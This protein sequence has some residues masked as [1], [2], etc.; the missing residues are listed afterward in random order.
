MKKYYKSICVIMAVM[1]ICFTG[2][3]GKKQADTPTITPST[4]T[5]QTKEIKEVTELSEQFKTGI[6]NF[7]FQIFE[8]LEDSENIFISPYSMAIAISMLDNGAEGSSKEEIEQMLGIEDLE[9]WN[10][11]VAYYMSLHEED[12][13]KLLTANSLWLSE[14]IAIS[15]NAEN[16]FFNPVK[17]YY[18]SE[19]NQMDLTSEDT[20]NQINSWVSDN[21]KGMI[22]SILDEPLDVNIKMALLN[23]VYFKGEWKE[24]FEE[25]NTE[26]G[27]FYGKD[28]TSQADMMYQANA[29]YKY[30][31][32]DN[33]KAIELPY[34][35]GKIVMDILIPISAEEGNE[36]SKN[37]NELFSSLSMEEK[38]ELFAALSVTDEQTI[39]ILELPKFELEYGVK[40]ISTALQAIGMKAPF[41]DFG[42]SKISP[43]VKV[44]KVLHKAKIQIDEKG[45]EASAATT[46]TMVNDIAA[47]VD[48][49]IKEFI[50]DQPFIFVIRDVENDMILFMG[51]IQNL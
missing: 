37:M 26:K 2:C 47:F 50:V 28:E 3:A 16:D 4:T 42:F 35:N 25:E 19:K 49:E 36:K 18:H 29:K 7:S 1:M 44:E 51:S 41:D 10:A 48:E 31:E 22:D 45:T 17:Q 24:P 20:M 27:Q 15:D 8:Q 40:D 38:V 9:N 43:D 23:A 13:S 32:K 46:V 21:T 11:C 5:S 33:L 39:S 12:A 30:L 14:D 34:E 6:N